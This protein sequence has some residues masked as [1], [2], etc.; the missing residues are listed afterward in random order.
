MYLMRVKHLTQC[1]FQLL[2]DLLITLSSADMMHDLPVEQ[3]SGESSSLPVVKLGW[4]FVGE[5]YNMNSFPEC[6]WSQ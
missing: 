2:L 6:S 4:P 5:N 3:A 1:S